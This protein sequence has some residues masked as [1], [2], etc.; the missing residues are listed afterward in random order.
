ML[1][2]N[3]FNERK[4]CSAYFNALALQV[5]TSLLSAVVVVVFNFLLREILTRIAKFEKHHTVT[6]EQQ[7]VMKK[8]FLAQFINTG[9]PRVRGG[10]PSPGGA[11]TSSSESAC[12]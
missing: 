1:A 12:Q 8:L 7:S 5:A 11:L 6:G 10:R 9:D 4:F 2:G 3:I